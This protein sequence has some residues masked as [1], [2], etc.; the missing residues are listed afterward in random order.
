MY[1]A[2]WRMTMP[3]CYYLWLTCFAASSINCSLPKRYGRF[4]WH[5]IQNAALTSG[6]LFIPNI[7][8]EL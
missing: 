2:Q 1:T 7:Y 4:Y 8:Y 6:N 3:V 5:T